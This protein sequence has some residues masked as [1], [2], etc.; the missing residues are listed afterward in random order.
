MSKAFTKEGD[1][2]GVS[3]PSSKSLLIPGGSFRIT[4]RGAARLACASDPSL[5]ELVARAEVLPL[6]PGEPHRVALGVTVHTRSATGV[7]KSYRIVTPEEQALT[8]EGCSIESPIGQALLGAH[9]GDVRELRT[10]RG[11]FEVEV[12]ALE[13]D[14]EISV[15]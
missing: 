13:G 7:A 11:L 14:S 12:L 10:P 6:V 4:A 8:G 15:P 2:T 1:D 5:R 3:L 9:M